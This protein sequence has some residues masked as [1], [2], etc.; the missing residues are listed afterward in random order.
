[1]AWREARR[2]GGR[3]GGDQG[4]SR[5]REG[6]REEGGAE[7]REGGTYHSDDERGHCVDGDDHDTHEGEEHVSEANDAR[8]HL[9]VDRLEIVREAV[10]HAAHGGS[11]EPG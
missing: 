7:G 9:L 1:M 4:I 10:A 2:E 8:H 6:G 11:V 5:E 3:E